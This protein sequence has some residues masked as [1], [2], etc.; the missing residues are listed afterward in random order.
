M[1]H[2]RNKVFG[3]DE[4]EFV[5]VKEDISKSYNLVAHKYHQLFRNE[6]NQKEYDREIL[7]KFGRFFDRGTSIRN[8]RALPIR[9]K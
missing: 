4:L 5:R 7:D 2:A 9:N 3:V 6:M 1:R 8:T